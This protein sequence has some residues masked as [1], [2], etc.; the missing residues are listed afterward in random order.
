MLRRLLF[1][2]I[3]CGLPF[4]AL[5]P[6]GCPLQ[7]LPASSPALSQQLCCPRTVHTPVQWG[8]VER[9]PSSQRLRKALT[10]LR[11][12]PHWVAL[13]CSLLCEK[14]CSLNSIACNP[15]TASACSLFSLPDK[16]CFKQSFEKRKK[17]W[18][19]PRLQHYCCTLKGTGEGGCLNFSDRQI[20]MGSRQTDRLPQG[21]DNEFHFLPALPAAEW[22]WYCSTC[23]KFPLL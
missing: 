19:C 17:G 21:T 13:Q 9:E 7:L 3:S 1:P 11:R 18:A 5:T 8:M 16:P 23:A 15:N 22:G 6:L 12:A 2:F 4:Y 10:P 14:T 20:L